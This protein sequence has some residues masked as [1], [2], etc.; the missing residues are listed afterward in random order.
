LNSFKSGFAFAPPLPPPRTLVKLH[1][2]KGLS[3]LSNGYLL[4]LIRS[5]V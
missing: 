1:L 3:K 2:Y 5:M 4:A